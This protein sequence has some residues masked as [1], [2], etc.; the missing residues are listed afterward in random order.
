[1]DL[2]CFDNTY[3]RFNSITR[4]L[5]KSGY[6]VL[7]DNK[8]YHQGLE[9]HTRYLKQSKSGFRSIM[10]SYFP[11]SKIISLHFINSID[12]TILFDEFL[13]DI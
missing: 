9:Q 11:E 8:G 1:M 5:R 2:A 13:L 7:Y 3:K 4:E 10:L 12:S 6:K